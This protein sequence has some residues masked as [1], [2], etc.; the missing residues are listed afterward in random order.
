MTDEQIERLS[1]EQVF[2][3]PEGYFETFTQRM[4][5]Q[6]PQE[7]T[8][9]RPQRKSLRR[10]IWAAASVAVLIAGAS[11]LFFFSKDKENAT[12]QVATLS[13]S[14]TETISSEELQATADYMMIDS[15]EL[16]AYLADNF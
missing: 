15:D 4:M 10:P 16:Y 3:V 6:I 14:K 11:A 2:K 12:S 9:I 7:D 1:K 5:S 13:E 8:V